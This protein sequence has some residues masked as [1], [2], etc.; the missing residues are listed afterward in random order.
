MKKIEGL[1]IAVGAFVV[2]VSVNAWAQNGAASGAPASVSA[3]S[4]M[5]ASGV[6]TPEAGRKANRALR[7]K[8]YAAIS[9]YR[10]IS[11]G[12]ISVIARDGAVTLNGTVTDAAQIDQV[13][14][15]AKGVTGV[16]SVT[17]KLTVQRPFGGQ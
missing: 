16:T 14:E 4:A 11:A 17:N 5:V 6:A 10:E 2:A 13:A 9:K 1:G 12:S 3:A 15:I 8:V 7:R